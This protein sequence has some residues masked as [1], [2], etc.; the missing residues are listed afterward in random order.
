MEIRDRK[1][2]TNHTPKVKMADLQ[3]PGSAVYAQYRVETELVS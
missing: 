2:D 1:R 3:S